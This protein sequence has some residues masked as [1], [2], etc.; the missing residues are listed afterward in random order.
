M[1]RPLILAAVVPFVTLAGIQVVHTLRV[2][3]YGALAPI[4]RVQTR[5]RVIG[6]SFDDGPTPEYTPRVLRLLER[7]DVRATFFVIG[8]RTREYPGLV[9]REVEAG[10]EVGVHTWTHPHLPSLSS[11]G[12]DV[13]IAGTREYLVNAQRVRPHLF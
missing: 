13:E 6:L 4:C 1:K 2:H 7:Y 11:H 9:R 5:Q 12:A 8:A 10:M 3:R